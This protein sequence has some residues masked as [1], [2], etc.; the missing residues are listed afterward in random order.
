M[1][2]MQKGKS[3]GYCHDGKKTF[4]VADNKNCADC[5]NNKSPEK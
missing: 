2:S 4:D 5:Q 1:A 3:C